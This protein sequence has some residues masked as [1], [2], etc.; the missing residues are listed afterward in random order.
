MKT[1]WRPFPRRAGRLTSL[2]CVLSLFLVMIITSA[3]GGSAQSQ[4]Q[5]SQGKSRLDQLIAH[6]QQIGVPTQS[7]APIMRQEQQLSSS[8]APFSPFNDQPDTNFYTHQAAQYNALYQ[9]LQ[10]LI[11]TTTGQFQMQASL[12]LQGFQQMLSRRQTQKIG[13]LQFFNNAY[14]QDQLLFSQ[15]K[16]PKDFAAVR[17][18][19]QQKAQAL[20]QLGLAYE[21]FTSFAETITQMQSAQLDVSVLQGQENSDLAALNS[22]TTT[23]AL[24]QL[25]NLINAQYTEALAHSMSALPYVEAAKL[26][27]F[28]LQIKL[29]KSYGIDP[30][31]YQQ[32]YNTDKAAMQSVKT[33]AQYLTVANR[34][35]SD[36]ASMHDQLVTGEATALIGQLNNEAMS[37]G[38][39][40]LYHDTFDGNNYILDSGYTMNGIG[41][42]L[43][44][45]LSW[46]YTP[47]DFQGVLNDEHDE[48]FSLKM[49]EQDYA[50]KT[51]FNQAHQTDQELMQYYHLSG[52]VIVVSMLEQALRLYQNGKLVRAFHVTTGRVE[53]PSL[54]GHW[55]VLNRASPTEFTSSDPPGSPYWYPPTPIHY[56][57]NYHWDGYFIHDAW[58]RV[59]FG[60]GTQFPHYDTGGDES[61][62][63]NGS[64]GCINMQEND[65]AWLYANT[66]YNTQIVVY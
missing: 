31:Q 63:G 42:W 27:Q 37:W 54:P 36:I 23:S 40:H 6:A 10:T 34:V 22:A 16:Y 4:Q 52:Q 47:S 12:N 14:Q 49:M 64:H 7:L 21:Q 66:D 57:I 18:D 39:A 38:N 24:Q 43:Q 15:A 26:Q 51:P 9:Q 1:W 44:L 13:D 3:C 61:F 53:L 19:A 30:S 17:D 20:G 60:P 58:W 46:A 11:T 55:T 65:A 56:A 62:A 59:N 41:Y 2:A 8:G 45:E 50:D 35:N 48:L 25:E 5:A 29:L 28:Q 32:L 33:L